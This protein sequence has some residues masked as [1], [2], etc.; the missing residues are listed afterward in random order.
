MIAAISLIAFYCWWAAKST[1]PRLA[2]AALGFGFAGIVVDFFADTLFIGWIPE[3]YATYAPFTTIMSEVV[4]NG[5]YSIAGI[6]LMLA[7]PPMR[8]WFRAWG[9]IVWMA[10]IALAIAGAMRWNDAIVAASALLL[11]T[12]I[13]WVWLASRFIEEPPL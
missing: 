2:L 1:R 13:P 5:L 10:G 11:T 7:S 9:W 8:P 12:F 3:G 6:V 4:A